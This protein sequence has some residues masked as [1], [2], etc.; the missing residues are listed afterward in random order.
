MQIG[1]L[2]V[3]RWLRIGTVLVIAGG[4]IVNWYLA[5]ALI[6]PATHHVGPPPSDLPFEATSIP[7]ESGSMLATWYLPAANSTATLV[8]LHPIRADR[9]AMLS[10]ARLFHDAG[11]DVILI[12]FQAHG[13]SAGGHITAGYV[14]RHDARAAVDFARKRNPNHRIGVVGWSLGGAATLLASPLAIDALVLESVYPSISEAVHDRV[15]M[16]LGPMSYVLSPVLLTEFRMRLG[17]SPA[18]LRPIDHIAGVGCP[19]L[20]ASGDLDQHTTLAET[21][22]LFAAAAEPKRLVVFQGAAHS[23]LLAYN[24]E[25]YKREVLPF[26]AANLSSQ[27]P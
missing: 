13:E 9:R 26:L 22:S 23:D 8:L 20:V 6:A 1:R 24:P 14:E 12:D 17:I 27:K 15:A 5:N 7:S 11:Y 25:Q 2:Q 10:R 16:R 4:L 3:Y 19:V 18:D 21:K